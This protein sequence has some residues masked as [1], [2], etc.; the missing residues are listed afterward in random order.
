MPGATTWKENWNGYVDA[1]NI[2]KIYL[3]LDNDKTG[4]QAAEKLNDTYLGGKA[5]VIQLPSELNGVEVSDVGEWVQAGGTSETFRQLMKHSTGGLL[6]SVREA[7]ERWKEIEGNPD[8]AGIKFGI[9]HL[10]EAISPGIL[11]GQVMVTLA[12]TGAGKTVSMLNFFHRMKRENPDI[13]ILFLSLEQTSNEWFERAR[14]IHKFY[15]PSASLED[16]IS[17]WENNFMIV[18]KNRLSDKDVMSCIEQFSDEMGGVDLV[19]LDYLGYYSGARQEKSSYERTSKGIMSVKEIAKEYGVAFYTPHQVSRMN[20]AGKEPEMENARDSGV[21]EE[22]S[23]YVLALWAPDQSAGVEQ[24]QR[25]GEVSMKILKSRH[26]GVG[27]RIDMLFTPKT[28]AII[29]ENDKLHYKAA[30]EIKL[31]K[32]GDDLDTVVYRN[33]TG[34][35]GV[36]KTQ[37]VIEDMER[38][39]AEGFM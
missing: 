37:Q 15:H 8:L 39:K 35:D 23:D 5:K 32:V 2:K 18:E 11:P 25:T 7:F 34:W 24:K 27:T 19:A 12:K 3:C 38:L 9:P 4:V 36:I 28:L 31:V 26:G 22:T 10:D 21:V 17:F 14:R 30:D 6:M 20:E 16:T 33:L 13:K 29:P 1:E